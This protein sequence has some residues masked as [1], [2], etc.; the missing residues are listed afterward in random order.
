[1]V[2]ALQLHVR[3]PSIPVIHTRNA[4]GLHR[5]VRCVGW[6]QTTAVVSVAGTVTGTGSVCDWIRHLQ[7]SGQ[8]SVPPSMTVS[9]PGRHRQGRLCPAGH[10]TVV[11]MGASVAV[12]CRASSHVHTLGHDSVSW[13]HTTC[14]PLLQRHS[15]R[16]IGQCA[17]SVVAW[18]N[19]VRVNSPA[20]SQARGRRRPGSMVLL[21]RCGV[22]AAFPGGVCRR[23][24]AGG[25]ERGVRSCKSRLQMRCATS[26]T[27]LAAWVVKVCGARRGLAVEVLGGGLCGWHRGAYCWHPRR[28]VG[29]AGRRY[30]VALFFQT[31]SY[32]DGSKNLPR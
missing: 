16:P 14:A 6:L 22:A 24:C 23:G 29:L 2:T 10:V 7:T 18:A 26:T 20:N 4:P 9:V 3:Q 30:W 8:P 15:C 28:I 5:H 1:M 17:A 32:F 21:R 12:V 25:C 11:V 13:D 31:D 27:S 19:V